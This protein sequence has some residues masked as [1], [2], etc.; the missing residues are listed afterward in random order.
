MIIEKGMH[1]LQT[2]FQEKKKK[3]KKN[4]F[5]LEN[6]CVM[7]AVVVQGLSAAHIRRP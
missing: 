5:S 4:I 1:F 6:T 2:I 7:G 3:Q